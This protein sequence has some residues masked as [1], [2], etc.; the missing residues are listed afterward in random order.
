MLVVVGLGNPGAQYA[1]TRHNIGFRVVDALAG[2]WSLGWT[3]RGGA[4]AQSLVA[5]GSRRGQEI[6]L[7]KPQT[8]MNASGRALEAISRGIGF[9][10]QEVIVILDDFNIEFGRVRV[11]SAG[12]DG[13][14]NGL[15]SILEFMGTEE[16]PRLRLGIGP[17]PD[18]DDD[19]DYVLM[20]F[21]SQEDVVGLVSRGC[22]AVETIIAEGFVAAMNR[23][24]GSSPL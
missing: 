18:A 19:I 3:N 11:R 24:N 16:I 21:G 5:S 6:L 7:V 13:G 10:P 15:A 8:Y 12:G 9:D 4:G 14:H 23:F 20:K 2:K 17:V 1:E 22:Q